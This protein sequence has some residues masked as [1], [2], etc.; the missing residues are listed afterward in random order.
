MIAYFCTPDLRILHAVW[1]PE[2]PGSF[3]EEARWAAG[4]YARIRPMP[5]PEATAAVRAAHEAHQGAWCGEGDRLARYDHLR[6]RTMRPLGEVA[7]DL[8]TLLVDEKPSD[9]E[10]REIDW[11]GPPIPRRITYPR[12]P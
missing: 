3:L 12:R 8:F 1:G 11:M 5:L 4:L 9:A 10:I 2:P 6:A 7:G